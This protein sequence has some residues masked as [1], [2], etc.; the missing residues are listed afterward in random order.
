[1]VTRRVADV[2]NV[3]VRNAAFSETHAGT[4]ASLAQLISPQLRQRFVKAVFNGDFASFDELMLALDSAPNWP[5]AHH[6]IRRH[7]K[8]YGIN[9]YFEEA[10]L[11]SN[12]IYRRYF[13]HDVYV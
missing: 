8:R 5:H 2:E 9:P 4:M 12:L 3:V 7:F 1:M 10:A 11:F 6:L 13:P